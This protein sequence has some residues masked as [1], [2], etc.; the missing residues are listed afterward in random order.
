MCDKRTVSF[1][2]YIAA[3]TSMNATTSYNAQP[4]W[5]VCSLACSSHVSPMR[6]AYKRNLV[7]KVT[8]EVDSESL[9]SQRRRKQ[10][11]SGQA[12]CL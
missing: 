7:N 10:N 5:S 6:L 1:N 12:R 8:M 4:Q 3:N 2:T 11:W 9:H